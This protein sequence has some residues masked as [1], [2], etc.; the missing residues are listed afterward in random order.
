VKRNL[1]KSR[2][3]AALLGAL[4]IASFAEASA[5][6]FLD[7]YKGTPYQD[8]QVSGPQAIPGRVQCAYYDRGGEG[9]AYHD[10]DAKN[11]GSG[12]LNPADGTY[13]NEFRMGE[14]VD[15]SYTKF[16]IEDK[17]QGNDPID[18]SPYDLVQPPKGQ[19]YV[20]WTEP[21]EWFRITVKVARAGL[22]SG[23]LLYTSNRGGSI[24]VDVNGTDASGPLTIPTT[25]N[26]SDPIAWRQWHHWNLLPGLV[27][28]KLPAGN[29]VLTVHILT[30]GNMNLAYFDFKEAR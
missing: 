30:G 22:Y 7:T 29:S 2:L 12:A 5:T 17:S 3:R 23:D 27:K 10:S 25:F 14:G 8:S 11:N 15:T 1:Q 18:N 9:I 28:L 24:S 21:G 19:L 6:D 13:L 26:A 20:G 4:A 16:R